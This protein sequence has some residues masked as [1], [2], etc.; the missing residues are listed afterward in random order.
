[1]IL[2]WLK[3]Q[4]YLYR[5]DKTAKGVFGV[6]VMDNQAIALTCEDPWNDNKT[7]VSCV[8]EGSYECVPHFGAKYKNVWRLENVQGRSAILIHNGNTHENTRGCILVGNKFGILAGTPGI[9][10]SKKTLDKLRGQLPS[11]FTIHITSLIN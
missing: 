8:P 9:L 1:M 3:K 10:N 4:V 5:T 6:M 7:G 11:K 2:P